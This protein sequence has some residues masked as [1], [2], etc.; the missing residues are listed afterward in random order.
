ML[1]TERTILCPLNSRSWRKD[2]STH[3]AQL[4]GFINSQQAVSKPFPLCY[5]SDP[6]ANPNIWLLGMFSFIQY[7]TK[8]NVFYI[9]I[10]WIH[11]CHTKIQ[12]Q[13]LT[14]LSNS[15]LPVHWFLTNVGLWKR[16]E[17]LPIDK[18]L[19]TRI[20]V[21]ETFVYYTITN[22]EFIKNLR[23][24]PILILLHIYIKP[25]RDVR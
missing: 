5:A 23:T 7:N 12:F 20:Y 19:Y 15:A 1:T 9:L 22:S 18:H 3:L 6:D 13:R 10:S 2:T 4:N 25:I 21:N 8:W 17:V 24:L 11:A 14:S 16:S